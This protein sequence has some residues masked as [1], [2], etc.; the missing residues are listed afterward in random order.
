MSRWGLRLT[1]YPCVLDRWI[2]R[3]AQRGES[4]QTEKQLAPHALDL[5]SKVP[6]VQAQRQSEQRHSHGF[7]IDGGWSSGCKPFFLFA[8]VE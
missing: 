4:K 6:D 8:Q 1:S 7:L 2:P 5:P 3:D